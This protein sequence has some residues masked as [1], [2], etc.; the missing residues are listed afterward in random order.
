MVAEAI[1][2]IILGGYRP[3][4]DH[5]I[6]DACVYG[7]P[8]QVLI[9]AWLERNGFRKLRAFRYYSY[10]ESKV[11]RSAVTASLSLL[12]MRRWL[13][14]KY[15]ANGFTDRVACMYIRYPFDMLD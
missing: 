13:Q 14:N 10:N 8:L 2:A 1:L 12:L 3:V 6:R 5:T 11:N 4:A 7:N 9:R 15:G